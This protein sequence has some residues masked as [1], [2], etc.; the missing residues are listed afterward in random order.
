MKIVVAGS[1]TWDNADSIRSQLQSFPADTVVVHGDTPGADELG[2][3]VARELGFTVKPMAKND[4]DY[5]QF[6]E[7]AWKGLNERMLTPDVDLVLAFHRDVDKSTGT[8]H[9]I[10]LANDAG[11]AVRVVDR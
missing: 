8:K 2:G 3:Q 10:E 11:I 6:K 1:T 9:L 4:S 7:V 5:E